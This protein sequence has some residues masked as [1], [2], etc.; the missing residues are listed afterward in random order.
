MADLKSILKTARQN[1]ADAKTYIANLG[2]VR[3]KINSFNTDGNAA[4]DDFIDKY[5]DALTTAMEDNNTDMNKYTKEI[6]DTSIRLQKQVES[7]KSTLALLSGSVDGGFKDLTSQKIMLDF[8]ATYKVLYIVVCCK[9]VLFFVVMAYIFT[10]RNAFLTFATF[11]AVVVVFYTWTFIVNF[12]EGNNTGGG[13]VSGKLCADGTES[14]ATG[15]NCPPKP[16][17]PQEPYISCDL[18]PF[19]CCS[20]GTPSKTAE[21]KTCAQPLACGSTVYGCCPDG[22]TDRNDENGTNCEW[23]YFSTECADTQFGCCPNG[24]TKINAEGSNCTS[25]SV[26]GISAFGC[27]P[28]GELREDVA[29]SNCS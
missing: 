2:Q 27:C 17:A 11:V 28:K 14:N 1:A 9:V 19:G 21:R 6:V 24:L 15:S 8:A 3:E 13:D 18:S 10:A 29:G 22:L 4:I 26:C 12:F 25:A 5:P 16:P 20:D 7:A 23:E